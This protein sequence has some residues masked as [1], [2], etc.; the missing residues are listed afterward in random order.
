VST[1][2][3]DDDPFALALLTRQLATLGHVDGAGLGCDVAQGY[4]I[5]RPMQ[6]S[7]L[8]AW[9]EN[10]DLRRRARAATA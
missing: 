8:L 1:L 7:D 4:F 10:W 3:V 6:G 2:L 5:A 9:C